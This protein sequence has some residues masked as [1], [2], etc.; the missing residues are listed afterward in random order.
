MENS[1]ETEELPHP[2]KKKEGGGHE[3]A[4][5]MWKVNMNTQKDKMKE[6]N[7]EKEKAFRS[8][9]GRCNETVIGRSEN[10]KECKVAEEDGVMQQQRWV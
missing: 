4:V 9:L 8:I 2:K 6:C 7:D 5:A 1:E 10:A 3:E